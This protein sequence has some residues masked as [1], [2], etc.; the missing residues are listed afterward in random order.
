MISI[1]V[2]TYNSEKTIIETLDSINSQTYRDFEIVVS[3][4]CSKDNTVE[5]V[6]GW[7]A[8]HDIKGLVVPAETNKGIPANVNKGIKNANGN[9]IKIIAG[10]DIMYPNALEVFKTYY[11]KDE[12]VIWQSRYMC[13]G[14]NKEKVDIAN[15]IQLDKQFYASDYK[16]QYQTLVVGNRLVAPS[17]GLIKKEY[18]DVYGFYDEQYRMMEDY[19]FFLKLSKNGIAFRLLD[20]VLIGY[21]ISD[22]SVMGMGA[23]SF[24]KCMA[25]F[26]FS[27]RIFGVLKFGGLIE[28]VKQ[29]LKY[30]LIKNNL[31]IKKVDGKYKLLKI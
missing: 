21:R 22:S 12:N 14:K 31:L 20:D 19:P 13:F 16:K 25:D 29:T 9:L 7:L 26:Y 27:E 1:V 5:V 18:Y 10:D 2:V 3:D 28:F 11:D 23:K 4:D 24:Y 6:R 17:I 15:S 8:S 30:S